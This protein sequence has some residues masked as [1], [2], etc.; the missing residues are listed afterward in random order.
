MD[1]GGHHLRKVSN[2]NPQ[3]AEM[4]VKFQND[5]IIDLPTITNFA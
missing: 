1:E 4:T 2:L 3:A 5:T